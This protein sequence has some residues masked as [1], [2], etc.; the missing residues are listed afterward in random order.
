MSPGHDSGQ[1]IAQVEALLF[2]AGRP[3]TVRQLA[4]LIEA[5]PKMI[6]AAVAALDAV[7]REQARGLSL[8]QQDGKIQ[9]VTN[10]Q[11][12]KLIERFIKEEFTGPLSRAALETLA[13]IAY[14]G[15]I[16]KPQIDTVRGVN[17]AIMLRTL[18]IRGLVERRRSRSDARAYEYSLS[19]D[20]M[21]HLG[22]TQLSELPRYPELRTNQVIERLAQGASGASISQEST[23]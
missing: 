14:R 9:L 3:L 16:P 8:I 4:N 11:Y 6:Q 21:R 13:I 17:S 2:A 7:Y 15:P 23:P 1:L 12:G 5:K 10:P 20:F 22:I 18:L 19:L